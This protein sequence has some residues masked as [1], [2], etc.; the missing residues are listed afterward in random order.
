MLSLQ[1]LLSL[2]CFAVHAF[3]HTVVFL[4]TQPKTKKK[5]LKISRELSLK[6]FESVATRRLSLSCSRTNELLMDQPFLRV[7]LTGLLRVMLQLAVIRTVVSGCRCT[8]PA[9]SSDSQ[10]LAEE[11][12]A[13]IC[14]PASLLAL[15]C[16]KWI[17]WCS[18]T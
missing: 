1:H 18:F 3:A 8:V 17:I 2:Q 12:A 4:C 6:M 5:K 13:F 7:F 11:K 10:L 15:W 9:S 14:P 16:S